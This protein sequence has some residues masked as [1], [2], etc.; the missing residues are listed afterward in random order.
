MENEQARVA[1]LACSGSSY[2]QTGLLSRAGMANL[3]RFAGLGQLQGR[4]LRPLATG[5]NLI[6]SNANRLC[7]AQGSAVLSEG[8]DEAADFSIPYRPCDT[9][10]SFGGLHSQPCI[11]RNQA[12]PVLHRFMVLVVRFGPLLLH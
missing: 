7:Y 11:T 5:S 2:S 8:A 6:Q 4:A 10:M 3:Q 12:W 1:L 9:G